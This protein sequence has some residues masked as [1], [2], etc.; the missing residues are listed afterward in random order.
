MS[1]AEPAMFGTKSN[2]FAFAGEKG[3]QVGNYTYLN[4]CKGKSNLISHDEVKCSFNACLL[5]KYGSF[6]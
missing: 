6:K 4:F 2:N 1:S 5:E 3:C